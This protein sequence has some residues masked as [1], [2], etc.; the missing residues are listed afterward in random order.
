VA[1]TLDAQA[2]QARR[3]AFLREAEELR[4]QVLARIHAWRGGLPREVWFG[5]IQCLDKTLREAL[6]FPEDAE[7]SDQYFAVLGRRVAG[8]AGAS[9]PAGLS[10]W[11]RFLAPRLRP[12]HIQDPEL[13]RP[14]HQLWNA[15]FGE[16]AE[17]RAPAG[18]D[19]ALIPSPS[20]VP[21]KVGI[22]QVGGELLFSMFAD[23]L[24]D[25]LSVYVGSFVIGGRD[26]PTLV[27]GE[28]FVEEFP[29]L[30]LES[31]E[32]MDDGVLLSYDVTS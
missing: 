1:G 12:D 15:A 2:V 25:E 14:F 24:I 16:S 28:G 19:P 31:V 8:V 17:A 18:Y 3:S 29:N 13:C 23:D 30:T 10:A 6:P 4:K 7:Q 11:F 22:D 9:P 32:R 20:S 26:A 27:D 5:E 21:R